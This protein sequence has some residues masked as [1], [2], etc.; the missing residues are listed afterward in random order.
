MW[1]GDAYLPFRRELSSVVSHN[2]YPRTSA[3]RSGNQH[4]AAEGPSGYVTHA[5]RGE[6]AELGR[7]AHSWHRWSQQLLPTRA[8]GRRHRTDR[9]L[10]RAQ[11]WALSAPPRPAGSAARLPHPTFHGPDLPVL[12]RKQQ[13][14]G[15]EGTSPAAT[16]ATGPVTGIR[17]RPT[18][19]AEGPGLLT[20]PVP[21]VSKLRPPTR[22]SRSPYPFI[23]FL[24]HPCPSLSCRPARQDLPGTGWARLTH[25]EMFKTWFLPRDRQPYT[26]GSSSAVHCTA[27]LGYVLWGSVT[28]FGGSQCQDLG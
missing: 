3:Q 8:S 23:S 26:L 11:A 27:D 21:A 9:P 19:I 16:I 5:G 28:D 7:W 13:R 14:G 17:P 1:E 24:S 2:R 6:G 18:D 20:G 25:R 4:A 22:A 12:T 15:L 10:P